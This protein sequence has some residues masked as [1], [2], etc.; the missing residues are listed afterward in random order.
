ML[1]SSLLFAAILLTGA[2]TGDRAE[3]QDFFGEGNATGSMR[4]DMATIQSIDDSLAMAYIDSMDGYTRI[5]V[6]VL[7]DYGWAMIMVDLDGTLG[8][9]AL[10]PGQITTIRG[11]DYLSGQGPS[12]E[13]DGLDLDD[14]T[15]DE[16]ADDGG[17]E[18]SVIGC[19]GPE[20]GDAEY[21]EEAEEATIEV[22]LDELTGEYIITIEADYGEAGTV[23][24]TATASP[25][26]TAI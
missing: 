19:S 18:G 10:A 17:L 26:G 1:R 21:D 7:G 8:E 23:S 9:G 4:G 6:H 25:S 5:E 11:W 24:G 12:E 22:Q 13:G 14:G 2:C 20:A 16:G 3:P 15:E